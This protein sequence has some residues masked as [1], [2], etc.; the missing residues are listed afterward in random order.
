MRLAKIS[1]PPALRAFHAETPRREVPY[2][3]EQRLG[4]CRVGPVLL[5]TEPHGMFRTRLDS[6]ASWRTGSRHPPRAASLPSRSQQ[7]RSLGP[8][9]LSWEP[10]A[11][12]WR[13][14]CEVAYRWSW[15]SDVGWRLRHFGVG[16]TAPDLR[17]GCRR[18]SQFLDLPEAGQS[19]GSAVPEF[20]Y[21][22]QTTPESFQIAIQGG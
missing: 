19:N 8:L 20:C 11:A 5:V 15:P 2:A 10:C 9:A 22:A 6:A 21:Q 18:A 12:A 4:W 7:E 17:G 3:R 13:T 16:A 1:V 14:Q